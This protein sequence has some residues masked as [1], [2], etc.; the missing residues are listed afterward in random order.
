[1]SAI[2][3][4]RDRNHHFGDLNFIQKENLGRK[5][6]FEIEPVDF[7]T[8]TMAVKTRKEAGEESGQ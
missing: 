2:A 7:K 3:R 5:G 1:M 6:A 4:K 8:D